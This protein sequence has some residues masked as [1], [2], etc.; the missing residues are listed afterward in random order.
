VQVHR[1][2]RPTLPEDKRRTVQLAVRLTTAE[3]E[4]LAGR[5][6][7]R[8]LAISDYVRGLVL[9]T[10]DESPATFLPAEQ[11]ELEAWAKTQGA[12]L[13]DCVK[14][15]LL[16][17][18]RVIRGAVTAWCDIESITRVERAHKHELRTIHIVALRFGQHEMNVV[19]GQEL[20]WA[21]EARGVP[22]IDGRKF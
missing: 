4:E 19:V 14:A 22:V 15:A 16:A 1:I 5:A 9:G 6:A 18:A 3:Q 17:T 13:E 2:G 8:G 21:L 10:L 20:A 11:E 7:K 12:P